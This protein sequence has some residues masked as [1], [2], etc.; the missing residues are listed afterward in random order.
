[1]ENG[2]ILAQAP[3]A[4]RPYWLTLLLR[5]NITMKVC[6]ESHPTGYLHKIGKEWKALHSPLFSIV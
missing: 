6:A 1:M 2:A 4:L 5:F 3:V